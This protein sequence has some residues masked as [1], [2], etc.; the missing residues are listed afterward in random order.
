MVGL[1][2]YD[3]ID[4]GEMSDGP[5]WTSAIVA[6]KGGMQVCVLATKTWL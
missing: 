6:I 5:A 2:D 3:R 4:V 1:K